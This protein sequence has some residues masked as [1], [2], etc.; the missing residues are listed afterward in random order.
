M[1]AKLLFLFLSEGATE[2]LFLPPDGMAIDARSDSEPRL[3]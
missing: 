1:P 3:E 2:K